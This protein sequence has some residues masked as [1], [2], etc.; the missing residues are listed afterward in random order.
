MR[1][2]VANAVPRLPPVAAAAGRSLASCTR[3]MLTDGPW[4]PDAAATNRFD[5]DLLRIRM[6]VVSVRVESA[7]ETLRGPAGPLFI[8]GGTSPGGHR[9]P[10][11]RSD[12]SASR[13]RPAIWPAARTGVSIDG[14]IRRS[15]CAIV[16]ALMG[17]LLISAVG[18]ALVLTTS[19][20]TLITRNFRDGAGRALRCGRRRHPWR[21]RA[22]AQA[23][24]WSA[25]L[26]G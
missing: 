3:S 22:V 10:F 12:R 23:P 4:C 19:V 13:C 2:E 1:D 9:L 21:S 15:G 20:D 6:I 17:V 7:N 11:R 8:R 5:A 16:V 26:A 25:V 18:T 14:P 24:D